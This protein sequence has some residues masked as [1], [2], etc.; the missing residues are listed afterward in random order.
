MS[1][2]R[3]I[4]DGVDKSNVEVI[5]FNDLSDVD[6]TGV[7]TGDF[8]Q[9]S[10]GDWV[11]F[12]L[13][14]TQNTWTANQIFGATNGITI[15]VGA[16]AVA[17][18]LTFDGQTADGV[19]RWDFLNDRFDFLNDINMISNMIRFGGD[20][21]F[22]T[23]GDTAQRDLFLSAG[24]DIQ[25]EIVGVTN[26]KISEGAVTI[27]SGVAGV[28]YT[29]TFDGETNDGIITWL[30]DEDQFQ[31]SDDI[32]MA[33]TEKIFF[34]DSALSINSSTDGQLDLDADVAISLNVDE[35]FIG[36]KITHSGDANTFIELNPDDIEFTAG[37]MLFMKFNEFGPSATGKWFVDETNEGITL[38]DDGAGGL[39]VIINDDAADVDF[40][41]ESVNDAANFFSDGGS[42][43]IGIGTA[44][45]AI[46]A[47]LEINSTTGALLL[48]RLTTTQRD[49]LTAVNGMI[50]YNST[51]NVIESYENGSW[52]DT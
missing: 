30:E 16:F 21:T 20:N 9:K 25:C 12:D 41:I 52:V 32:I 45:P 23:G 27:G 42:N 13:F 46:S 14:G 11:D 29:L 35:V 3:I 22:I 26:L 2:P 1:G 6:T 34:R 28:D 18:T 43:N 51:N 24:Q 33:T 5:S 31:F 17:Y 40:R 48:P 44:L 36:N 39:L 15:G 7:S 37:G 4:I 10:A 47:K 50:I 8:I 49:A 38:I 19:I